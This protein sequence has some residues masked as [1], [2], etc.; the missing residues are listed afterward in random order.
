[1][2]P[3]HPL[4]CVWLQTSN[5]HGAKKTLAVWESPSPLPSLP[6]PPSPPPSLTHSP[7]H[8][9]RS[10]VT[11]KTLLNRSREYSH[12]TYYDH[13]LLLDIKT[14]YQEWYAT[15]AKSHPQKLRK[16]I[17]GSS[18]FSQ[19]YASSN[20]ATESIPGCVSWSHQ[21]KILRQCQSTRQYTGTQEPPQS[22]F[23]NSVS[24][25]PITWPKSL[26]CGPFG[27]I[28]PKLGQR[29]EGCM[30]WYS[31]YPWTYV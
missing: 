13:L 3:V 12:S 27:A 14:D 18:N 20:S 30:A 23:Q 24:S 10:F 7:T 28:F 1:M 9:S 29:G 25:Y 19:I 6:S 31:K 4:E 15:S 17:R 2:I 22:K 16:K 5:K 21:G 11:P 26:F 8:C